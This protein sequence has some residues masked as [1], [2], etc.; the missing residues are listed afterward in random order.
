MIRFLSVFRCGFG[1]GSEPP[2][3]GAMKTATYALMHLAVA[4]SV[5]F[6][7]TGDW[8]A[9][10]AIGLVEPLFQTVAYTLHERAW[11]QREG[12]GPAAHQG[13]SWP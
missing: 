8:R 13:A 12:A 6:A 11:A 10:L 7:L 3:R 2:S 5:A 1:H 4:M 9:A